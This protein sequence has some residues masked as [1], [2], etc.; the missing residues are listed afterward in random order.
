LSG[1]SFGLAVQRLPG[2]EQV[3]MLGHV[4]GVRNGDGWFSTA[5]L[6]QM[7]ESLRLPSPSNVSAVLSNL[8]NEKNV[9][10]RAA[11]PPWGLT[12]QGIDRAIQLLGDFDYAGI[13]AELVGSPGAEFAHVVHSVIPPDFAPPRWQ[14]GISRLLKRFPFETN[15]FCMTRFPNASDP[16]LP[17][18]VEQAINAARSVTKQHGL[19]LHLAS[20]RIVEDDLLGNVGAYMWA[21]QYGIGLLED[22]LSNGRG[23][24]ANML[25]EI[26]SMLMIG[27]RCA[28]LKDRTSPAPP[29]DLSGQIYKSVDF[30]FP[31]SVAA[32]VHEWLSEDLGRGRCEACPPPVA[33]APFDSEF[34]NTG[35]IA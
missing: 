31:E 8:R 13:N 3:L 1:T 33:M 28:I 6:L 18:P 19:T 10:R 7:F 29:S 11:V 17:D 2:K 25:I 12:P 5:E 32:A 16:S 34:I 35:L 24:N 21:C 4:Q 14:L 23:L 27:R 9:V 30:D 26:G 15:I 22:R 20:D